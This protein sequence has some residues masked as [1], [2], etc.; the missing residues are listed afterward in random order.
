MDYL[1]IFYSSVISLAVLFILA[2]I[3]G[4]RQISELSLFDY[5]NGITIGSIA[6]EMATTLEKHWSK[7]LL[8][9]VIYGLATAFISFLC[10]KSLK[11]RRF[12][13]GKAIVLYDKG[14]F[15]YDG[16]K[17]ARLD[18]N[19]FLCQCRTAGYFDISEIQTAIMEETGKISILPKADFRPITPKDMNL[20]PPDSTL[21][22]N[23]VIDG[24]ILENNLMLL[25]F[26]KKWLLNRFKTSRMKLHDTMLATVDKNGT[27]SFYEKC[28]SNHKGDIF[29]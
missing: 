14:K 15:R 10:C 13:G 8:A 9:M 25:G 27:V 12:F 24:V 2:K 21:A 5:I 7:P 1:K 4:N 22:V 3:I 16:L 18:I 6:A 11:I 17:K 29:S 26:D 20:S 28:I 23:V 19:E